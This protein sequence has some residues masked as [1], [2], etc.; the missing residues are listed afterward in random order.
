MVEKMQL[1]KPYF[2]V[3]SVLIV[4]LLGCSSGDEYP[5]NE[6]DTSIYSDYISYLPGDNLSREGTISIIFVDPIITEDQIGSQLDS[7]ILEF[8]PELDGEAIWED[9]YT[10]EWNTNDTL[11]QGESYQ[12]VLYF[13]EL[14]NNL[15][16]GLQE[17]YFD[18]TI[19]EL[20][21]YLQ[22]QPLEFT[23]D[24]QYKLDVKVVAEDFIDESELSKALEVKQN[25][26]IKDV[27]IINSGDR[28]NY[29]LVID[30]IERQS[31]ESFLNITLNETEVIRET[32]NALVA[33]PAK[34]I[35]NVLELSVDEDTSGNHIRVVFSEN[36]V[37]K[38]ILGLVRV[39]DSSDLRFLIENNILKIFNYT[40]TE[41]LK[42]SLENIESHSG[43]ILERFEKEI[44]VASKKPSINLLDKGN[45]YTLNGEKV[46]SIETVNVKEVVVEVSYINTSNI[47]QFFQVNQY[48]K[49]KE[50]E[51][52][53]NVVHRK[54]YD[55]GVQVYDLNTSKFSALDISPLLDE[56]NGGILNVRVYFDRDN[57]IYECEETD[58]FFQREVVD[59]LGNKE[60]IYLKSIRFH[61]W[62]NRNNP[63]ERAFYSTYAGNDNSFNT[64]I[65][66]SDIGIIS[67]SDSHRQYRI[68]LNDLMDGGFISSAYVEIYNYQQELLSSGVSDSN[69]YYEYTA[70][71]DNRPYIIK[72]SFNGQTTYL[73][74][75]G[76]D[77]I[78]TSH[79]DVGGISRTQAVDG[80]TYTDRGV[81]RPGDDIYLNLIIKDYTSLL[82]QGHPAVM[83]LK[84]PQ[85]HVV[86]R[87][88]TKNEIQGFFRFNTKTL[89]ES[90]TGVYSATITIGDNEFNHSI[91]VES[92]RP[93]RIKI[94]LAK[95][96]N[97]G[98]VENQNQVISIDAAWLHGEPA[99]SLRAQVE[100]SIN[101]AK[102]YFGQYSGYEFNDPLVREKNYH[103]QTVFNTNLDTSG[104]G[105]FELSLPEVS[106]NPGNLR[107]FFE[108]KVF[109][110]GGGFSIN[111]KFLDYK[112]YTRYVGM[113]MAKQ[114]SYYYRTGEE[115]EILIA[116]VDNTGEP[117]TSSES[118]DIEVYK[119]E[120]SWWWERS[121]NSA[122]ANYIK[123]EKAKRIITDTI[124]INDGKGSWK[125]NILDDDWGRYLIRVS[126]S[127]GQHSSGLVV[128]FYR[129]GVTSDLADTEGA[130]ILS[131]SS[132]KDT[133]SIDEELKVTIPSVPESK[134]LIQIENSGKVIHEQWLDSSNEEQT[135]YTLPVDESMTPNIYV[136]AILLQNLQNKNNDRP[137]KMY[138]VIPISVNNPAT[139][140]E[141]ILNTPLEARP[142][143]EFTIEV[144]EASDK[145]MGYTI[146]IVDEGLLSLTN[147]NTPKPW[148]YFYNTKEPSTLNLWDMY[149]YLVSLYGGDLDQFLTIGG[150]I[151]LL[152]EELDNNQS[153]LERFPP[154][155][156]F[157]GPFNLVKGATNSHTIK[158][159]NY[160]GAARVMLIAANDTDFGS[161]DKNILIR[162]PIMVLA[163][164]PRLV[165]VEEEIGIPVTLFSMT[166]SAKNVMV[167]L[168]AEGDVEIIGQ[169][170]QQVNFSSDGEE[171][172]YFKIKGGSVP[173]VGKV[174]V[175]GVSGSESSFSSIDF[176][177]RVPNVQITN[178]MSYE[179]DV[180][181]EL[182][183]D[184]PSIGVAGANYAAIEVSASLPLNLNHRLDYLV[185]YPHGCIEQTTSAAFPQIYLHKL[186]DLSQ[187]KLNQTQSNVNRT[188]REL[189]SRFQNSDGGFRYWPSNQHS[190][191]W[192]TNY[193]GHF[194]IEAR[195][196]GYS[197][198]N[199][200]LENWFNYQS[201]MATQYPRNKETDLHQAYRLYTMALYGRGD[202]ASMNR[203]R[204][205][206]LDSET[207]LWYLV[208][209]Y[210]NMG[211]RQ[212]AEN[213]INN[214]VE[215]LYS[216]SDYNRNRYLSFGSDTRDKAIILEAMLESGIKEGR[217]GIAKEI[218]DT[219]NSQQWMSTQTAAFALMA[220]A[221]YSLN[222]GSNENIDFSVEWGGDVESLKG[223]AV[224]VQTQK[225]FDGESL[226]IKVKNNGTSKIF[227]QTSNSGIPDLG[228]EKVDN[229]KVTLNI[230]YL[231]SLGKV[232]ED[233]SNI[234]QGEDI[235]IEAN[236]R[237]ISQAGIFNNMALS[238]LIPSGWEIVNER[239]AGNTLGN[240]KDIDYFDIRDDRALV[241]FD[242]REIGNFTYKI[243]VNASYNGDY[244]LP[245]SSVI[246]MY[247]NSIHASTQGQWIR[248]E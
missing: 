136:H 81:Y 245:S 148:S 8:T 95:D 49:L 179:L 192:A 223:E 149:S 129:W 21:I 107:L 1:H 134:I 27:T 118:L 137:L 238:L 52:V 188:I 174:I 30:G 159:P 150:G 218:S 82:T 241:Y 100:L 28:L 6:V 239:L 116:L 210:A 4:S 115:H 92:I 230:R 20:H 102:T 164:M 190:N 157:I 221:K 98:F 48:D 186:V 224:S 226:N 182:V 240:T 18:F 128:P 13:A 61:N 211:N 242:M 205:S 87:V 34:D 231:D 88:T 80:F 132:E 105:E 195:K 237:K 39:N 109:E 74:V 220:L 72:A 7:G 51:R 15:P 83:E 168:E 246:S 207:A 158:V 232:I 147:F 40:N 162:Q 117:I 25:D 111:N 180:A 99:N 76:S 177:V 247:D 169:S 44:I 222:F 138:G 55:L 33:V 209:S 75:R 121:S 59:D 2:I 38:D 140:L 17:I 212:T 85:G 60:T 93:N 165:S 143:S 3:F 96:V 12:G 11:E 219:L 141:P 32:V 54:K 77:V 189:V 19:R 201:K 64:N 14:V 171:T 22:P 154:F 31:Q 70:S 58:P 9:R 185:N 216:G 122:V 24:N 133:Y 108:T 67:S 126:D 228:E 175:K 198:S 227:L 144:E 200:A 131:F 184:L 225:Y 125:I 47:L 236:V 90:I 127:M 196:Q 235:T 191:Q 5:E 10:L 73:R 36:I 204:E 78:N 97:G 26:N 178:T 156:E 139:K 62:Q 215:Y 172:I 16:E 50:L 202:L 66:V 197:V 214:S 152:S 167:S 119:L 57:I 37:Q 120:W 203:L 68:Y 69:G 234:R 84:D 208:A 79:F 161:T 86:D 63:C 194:L 135:I 213:I 243:R 101:Q 43:A 110:R 45:I 35:F 112:P 199:N 233:I 130:S 142:N 29:T 113:R 65:M 91:N 56:Y 166:E 124:A 160:I 170:Q 145:E 106:S 173:G 104:Y 153:E 123:D 103:K 151:S 206:K 114:D 155:V 181:Q 248:I 94:E 146:A 46:I 42:V 193:A 217:F 71:F 229:S 183:I 244:Y 41:R 23:A 89:K 163:D 176:E 187:E 53:A